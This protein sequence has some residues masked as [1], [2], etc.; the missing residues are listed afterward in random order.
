MSLFAVATEAVF[1]HHG[2]TYK[3][4]LEDDNAYSYV[5]LFKD[6]KRI[7]KYTVH[8]RSGCGRISDLYLKSSRYKSVMPSFLSESA[9]LLKAQRVD[10]VVSLNGLMPKGTL[11]KK[12]RA[13]FV[14]YT[15]YFTRAGFSFTG[16]ATLEFVSGKYDYSPLS[17]PLKKV[18]YHDIKQPKHYWQAM[19]PEQL[20]RYREMCFTVF[21]RDG[22]P[23]VKSD[24]GH[25]M[26]W[27]SQ[28]MATNI[29]LVKDDRIHQ[30]LVGL[31]LAWSFHPHA[32]S[33]PCNKG[34]L[35]VMEAFNDDHRLRLLVEKLIQYYP[36]MSK[37]NLFGRIKML[38]KVQ[39]VSNFRPTAAAALYEAFGGGVI[40]DMSGGW[41]GRMLGAYRAP[42]VKHYIATEP[43]TLTHKGLCEQAD[44]LKSTRLFS[45]KAFE[46]HCLG[47][48]VFRPDRHSIDFA[49]TSPPYFNCEQYS[50]EATQSFVKFPEYDA[51]AEGFLLGTFKNVYHGLK[52]GKFMA[53][54]IANVK[55]ADHIEED[56]LAMG[57]KAGFKFVKMMYLLLSR[58]NA[59]FKEEP[60]FIFQKAGPKRRS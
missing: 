20:D 30:N 58:Q 55:G 46:V 43:S 45:H 19:S 37:S 27:L 8:V 34:F 1:E 23:H 47:S 60:I 52:P 35:T 49:F 14:R 48:E 24:R 44:F 9:K 41:G 39:A 36:V 59:G 4:C 17:K 56:T 51:W 11:E 3:V 22:F 57:E 33:V 2:R 28:L 40:Q 16:T 26:E 6:G 25:R 5:R 18:T 32:W 31:A 38:S 21:R 7:A 54:N 10:L 53:I 50:T 29:D 42:S 15:K 13:L 12:R